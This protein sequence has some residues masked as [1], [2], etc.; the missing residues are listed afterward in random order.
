MDT[1]L[2]PELASLLEAGDP[3]SV[4]RAWRTFLQRHNDTI[5]KATR[6]FSADYDGQMDRYRHI[7]EELRRDDFT[8][9]RKYSQN[10]QGRFRTWLAVVCRR[11]CIDYHRS[12]YGR[13][14]EAGRVARD[15]RATRRRLVDLMA[16][17]LNPDGQK[18]PA[19]RSPEWELRSRELSQALESVVASLDPE[20]RL[21][22]KLRYDDGLPV[23]KVALVMRYPTVFHVYRRLRPLLNSMR[24]QLEEKGVG[25]PE[26]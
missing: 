1:T 20:D 9:L 19:G 2:P 12:L 3:A 4:D 23:R 26:P 13:D 11:L 25:G 24:E 10:P 7:L 16:D 6:C 22:L 8:R 17:Q 15:G 18:D 14:R 21:L 5:L